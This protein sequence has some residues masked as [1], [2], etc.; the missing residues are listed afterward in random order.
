M[1]PGG[2]SCQSSKNPHGRVWEAQVLP[3]SPEVQGSDVAGRRA[4]RERDRLC[5]D[6]AAGGRDGKAEREN[7]KN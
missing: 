5:S 3:R 6:N 7:V 4:R 2:F 1:R